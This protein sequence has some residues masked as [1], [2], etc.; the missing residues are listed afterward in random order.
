MRPLT[1]VFLCTGNTCRSPLAEVIA[2]QL[3]PNSGLRFRS[4]GIQAL[5][6]QSASSGSRM[7]AR[8]RGTSL[9]EHDSRAV[10]LELLEEASWVIGMTRAHVVLFK[11]RT[12]GFY[13]GKVGLLGEPGVDLAG[14]P[15]TP[16]AEEIADPIGGNDDEYRAVGKQIERLLA[17]WVP[18]LASEAGNEEGGA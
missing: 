10:T 2:R 17:A 16:P 3:M 4:A 1:I 18:Y 9:A 11:K 15:A 7:V 8:E 5:P 12:E 13:T 14:S 6:G